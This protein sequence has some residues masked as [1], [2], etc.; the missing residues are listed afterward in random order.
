MQLV[1]MRHGQAESYAPSDAVRE[2]TAKGRR[3]VVA[4]AN[5]LPT[6]LSDFDSHNN[7]NVDKW[8]IFHSPY[9]RTTETANLFHRT[10]IEK[11]S[12]GFQPIVA[13]DNLLGGNAVEAVASWAESLNSQRLILISHQPLVSAL[14]AWLI[15]GAKGS[16]VYRYP[17]YSM[18]PASVA[19]LEGEMIGGAQ[20]G[21]AHML[22]C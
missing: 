7:K 22:H 3:D 11:A 15:E 17:E 6:V 21:L 5:R 2:L 10:L 4:I 16:E 19:V 20:M 18:A 14:V 8:Q 1:I 12:D 9:V 13:D